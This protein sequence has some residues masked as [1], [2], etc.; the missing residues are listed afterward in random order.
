MMVIVRAQD[1]AS[2]TLRR[3][4]GE[5]AHMSRQ[6]MIAAQRADIAFQKGQ[7][8]SKLTAAQSTMRGLEMIQTR[9]NLL[10][11][12]AKHLKSL[13]SA[14]SRLQNLRAFKSSEIRRAQ[15][16]LAI[17]QKRLD[18]AKNIR[19]EA[20]RAMVSPAARTAGIRAAQAQ[21]DAATQG[22]GRARGLNIHN[23]IRMAEG[24]LARVEYQ[25]RL[26]GKEIGRLNYAVDQLS[27][28]FMRASRSPA[29]LADQLGVAQRNLDAAYQGLTKA[30]R[31]ELAFNQAI[32]QMPIQRMH[33]LGQAMSGIGRTMQL[34]G[35]IGTVSLGLA[36]RSAAEFN[37]SLSLAA[38]QA[39][40]IDA[41]ASQIN[42]RMNEIQN[43][44][45][46]A[47]GELDG[48]LGLMGRFPAT[49]DEMT[50]SAYEIFSSMNLE[51]FG[52]EKMAKGLGLLASAN[53]LAVAGG[54]DLGEATNAMITV[55]NNFDPML[56]HTTEQ[57]D[58]MFDI[59]R[60]GRMRLADF[61]IMMN[62]IAPAAADAGMKLA[63]VGGAMAFLTQV[64]PSQRMVATGISRLIEAL[65][66]PDILAGLRK[67]GIEAR[68]ASGH[69]RPLDDL[70]QEIAD[71]FPQL[72]TGQ[73]SAAE[74]F[75]ELSAI[76]RG[77]GRGQI[78]TAE[79]RRA[80]SEI[81]THFDQYM[82]AQR[83]I[84][85]NTGE[86]GKTLEQQLN[87]I[88]VQWGIF[89]NKLRALAIEIG[90]DAVPVF[91]QL[92]EHVQRFLNWW[93]QLNPETRKMIVQWAIWASVGSLVAGVLLAVS[94]ALISM[95]ATLRA[96]RLPTAAAIGQLGWMHTLLRG[97]AAFELIRVFIKVSM[98]GD[99]TAMDFI[100]AA[101]AGG[102]LGSRFG[103]A[104]AIVG[105]ITV[106]VVLH[107]MS[108]ES[109]GEKAAEMML[110]RTQDMGDSARR[111]G[112][113][114]AETMRSSTMDQL[115]R[116]DPMSLEEFRNFEKRAKSL[117]G[118]EANRSR[119]FNEAAAQE[120]TAREKTKIKAKEQR[121]E[122]KRLY[123]EYQKGRD[124][125]KQY[126]K[127]MKEWQ[128]QLS[129]A[130]A[131]AKTEVLSNLRSMYM[132]MQQEN[133]QAFGELFQ[134][135][136][137]TSETFDIAKEWGVTPA[138]QDMI[139]DLNAQ[140]AQFRR[141]RSSLDD[142]LARGAPM[143]L[144]DELRAMGP[145][146]QSLIDQLL[147]TKRRAKAFTLPGDIEGMLSPG[148]IDIM[149][150]KMVKFGKSMASV[151]SISIGTDRGTVLIPTV[152]N[153]K[154]V[155]D[156]EAIKHYKRTGKNLGIFASRAAADAYAQ[157]LHE[158]QASLTPGGDK[159]FNKF[160]SAW[161]QKQKLIKQATKM[162][163]TNE[164][165]QFRSAGG[166]MGE[167]I[168]NG[169]K[170]AQVGLWFDGWV[171]T[172]F[173]GVINAAVQQAVN[174]WKTQN[175]PPKR[176]TVIGKPQVPTG[177]GGR[178]NRPT[179]DSH[180]KNITVNIHPGEH[181]QEARE[182]AQLRQ[183]AFLAKSVIS[184]WF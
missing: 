50:A 109:I 111:W 44:I 105:A 23:A 51:R 65:R 147:G 130:T 132:G 92:G 134:G 93:K 39:R 108:Q 52:A 14:E 42:K 1:F 20:T 8:L 22:L 122:L 138:L 68:D 150:R 142:L 71:R 145:E 182:Q 139:R 30:Q 158:Q 103:P 57:F 178:G 60:F 106:P 169:F 126:G 13:A 16:E 155:S 94:G 127:S 115:A 168:I 149:N 40:D 87:T 19:R 55:L 49:S 171:K 129:Q 82:E 63:D 137:L 24:D 172:T 58:T 102:I 66:H 165:N 28:R 10:E 151:R 5:F 174:E 72:R 56:E 184:S 166:K 18:V 154:V 91:Q 121:D 140:V 6:Q 107:I 157:A 175:P 99:P 9:N 160:I 162:D 112:K 88:G 133:E 77:G 61:N 120:A 124:M 69:L 15:A 113:Y 27:P 7:A 180:D 95:A 164:I 70:M 146:A 62:K 29:V 148:N 47:R 135:P 25:S 119:R 35:A 143:G 3:V 110:A 84:E 45:S 98:G 17:A 125:M 2:R 33:D 48:I 46:G 177:G 80:F 67:F 156:A 159:L 96:L 4:G 83:N 97:L 85:Q 11:Q 31:A 53:K 86:F 163:F 26:T 170:A 173:P 90:T 136:W 144:I 34:F 152:I 167:A 176:P 181:A 153:G 128:A 54:A 183:A 104:G 101:I 100:K 41:P 36:A 161:K 123:D 21:I 32:R 117:T 81:M 74:F 37:T 38:T 43:G 116:L 179:S 114:M 89:T 64:M 118:A 12:Q 141:W 73:K 79:G 131:Q 78:F 59:V 75:R 76:G